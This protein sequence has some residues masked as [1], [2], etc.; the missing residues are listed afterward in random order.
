MAGPPP[1]PVIV[2]QGA[3]VYTPDR[4]AFQDLVA[5]NLAG[6]GDASD[7]FDSDLFATL[8]TLESQP[9]LVTDIG[10]A[11]T[12]AS[13]TEDVWQST[14]PGLAV[15]LG[16]ALAAVDRAQSDF[17]SSLQIPGQAPP[18]PPPVASSGTQPP[19]PTG[20]GTSPPPAGGSPPV[21]GGGTSQPGGPGRHTSPS[22]SGPLPGQGGAGGGVPTP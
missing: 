8:L 14:D 6:V 9:K 3:P 15:D 4:P 10:D 16:Q 19:P 1:R 5:Q 22:S 2:G 17:Q 20:G 12:L 13:S 21:T 18:P 11:L 7:K